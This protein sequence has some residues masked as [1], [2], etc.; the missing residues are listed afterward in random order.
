MIQTTSSPKKDIRI[1]IKLILSACALTSVAAIASVEPSC[2]EK[3]PAT[4]KEGRLQLINNGTEVKD[5]ETGLIWQRCSIGQT[6]DGNTC[7]G[8][9]TALGWKEAMQKAQALG[10]GYRLPTVNELFSIVEFKCSP[11]VNLSIFPNTIR[12][13]YYTS[14]PSNSLSESANK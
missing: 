12:G 3:L 8:E 11:N 9:A 13:R 6:W 1:I 4:I 2:N 14:T 10:N 5:T 7:S